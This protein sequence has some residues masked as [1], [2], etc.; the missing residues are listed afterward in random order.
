MSNQMSTPNKNEST[1]LANS[2]YNIIRALEKDADFLY[3]TVDQYVKDAEADNRPDLVGVWNAI[4][5][6]KEHHLQMLREALA[7]EARKDN[8]K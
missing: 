2:T 6:D 1:R 5:Q 4:R 3:S 8:L 7:G